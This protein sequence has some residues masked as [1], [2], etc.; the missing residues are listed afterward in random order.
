MKRREVG[1]EWILL[2]SRREK[3][4]GRKD[5]AGLLLAR[6]LGAQPPSREEAAS[7]DMASMASSPGLRPGNHDACA[8]KASGEERSKPPAALGHERRLG[9]AL[10][11]DRRLWA[12]RLRARPPAKAARADFAA[13]AQ[14]PGPPKGTGEGN[15]RGGSSH[16]ETS[17]SA[18]GPVG[19]STDC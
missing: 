5:L 12:D 8:P 3:L 13:G 1:G 9:M 10:G 15:A 14:S 19:F 6:I 2:A 18:E 16:P 4:A 17:R 11:R 7:T